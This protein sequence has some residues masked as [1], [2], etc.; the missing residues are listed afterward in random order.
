MARPLRMERA[1]GWYHV[2]ARGNERKAIYRDDL[3]RSHFLELVGEVVEQFR[4]RVHAYVLMNNHYHLMVSSLYRTGG[5]TTVAGAR[6]GLDVGWRSGG[7]PPPEISGVC[8]ESRARRLEDIPVGI[9]AGS[10]GAWES[11]VPGETETE[12]GGRVESGAPASGGAESAT[13]GLDGRFE[14]R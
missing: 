4:V 9:G 12:P 11:G 2:T 5:G 7:G 3:D 14:K 1:G 8:G 6:R 10:G 13:A